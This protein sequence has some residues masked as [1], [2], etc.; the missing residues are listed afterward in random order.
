MRRWSLRTL[1]LLALL[2]ALGESARLAGRFATARRLVQSWRLLPRAVGTTYQGFLKALAQVSPRLLRALA[3]HLRSQIPAVAGPHWKLGRWVV[4][5]VDGSKFNLPRTASMWKSF[6]AAGKR[7]SAPQAYL[8]TILHLTTGLPWDARLARGDASERGH[9]RRM[10]RS[11][12]EAALLVADAGF[13]GYEL[14][15]LLSQ[16]RVHFLIRVGANVK[17]LRGLGYAVRVANGIIRVC[18][19]NVARSASV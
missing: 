7:G 13:V 18:A 1:T 12:P 14:W 9:L 16:R 17:L 5:G 6:G 10:L 4:L 11:L 2:M 8:T 15:S 19:V 3:M